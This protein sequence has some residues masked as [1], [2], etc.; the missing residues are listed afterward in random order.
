[1]DQLCQAHRGPRPRAVLR[2]RSGACPAASAL[3]TIPLLVRLQSLAPNT[4][5]RVP[6]S[7]GFAPGFRHEAAFEDPH[8][9]YRDVRSTDHRI[10]RVVIHHRRADLAEDGRDERLADLALPALV[11]LGREDRFYPWA[12][13]QKLYEA[14]GARVVVLDEVGHSVQVEHPVAVAGLIRDFISA[15]EALP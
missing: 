12:P 4:L 13:A 8:Q 6:L 9:A 14:A 1:M 2:S 5:L 3:L 10:P 11:I 7:L 15:E